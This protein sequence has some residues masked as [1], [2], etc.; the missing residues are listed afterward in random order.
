LVV[1]RQQQP[2]QLQL[3]L[4]LL[5]QLKLEPIVLQSIQIARQFKWQLRQLEE[6]Q[7]Q[8]VLLELLELVLQEPLELF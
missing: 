7:W 8:L 2:I 4:E 5:L 1:L 3:V 6:S